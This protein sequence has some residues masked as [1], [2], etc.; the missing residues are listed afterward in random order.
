MS[1]TEPEVSFPAASS[2]SRSSVFLAYF[3]RSNFRKALGLE[4]SLGAVVSRTSR[5]MKLSSLDPIKTWQ[6]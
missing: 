1:P 6:R 2:G 4:Q 5:E 3:R